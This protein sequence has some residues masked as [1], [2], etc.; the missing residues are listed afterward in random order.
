MF[1]KT[2]AEVPPV[3]QIPV[4]KAATRREDISL[5]PPRDFQQ[6][7][8]L[9]PVVL[10]YKGTDNSFPPVKMLNQQAAAGYPALYQDPQFW[11]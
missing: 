4:I 6:R 9:P 2:A 3:L 11:E 8:S 5:E 10:E 7:I 1:K